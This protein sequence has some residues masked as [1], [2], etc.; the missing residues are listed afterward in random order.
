MSSYCLVIQIIWLGK[1]CQCHLIDRF[2]KLSDWVRGVNVILLI[3]F[4]NYLVG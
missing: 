1:G 2:F 3:G 4:S